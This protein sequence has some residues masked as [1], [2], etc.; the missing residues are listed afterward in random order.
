[1]NVHVMYTAKAQFLYEHAVAIFS[2]TVTHAHTDWPVSGWLYSRQSISASWACTFRI[3]SMLLRSWILEKTYTLFWGGC[4]SPFTR[5]QKLT[6]SHYQAVPR[7]KLSEES[8]CL[9]WS[10]RVL[11]Q[12]PVAISRRQMFAVWTDTDRP[13]ARP[14]FCRLSFPWFICVHICHTFCIH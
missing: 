6:F 5:F 12:H 3:S 11:P 14:A 4:S 9:N 13:D 10:L 7:I 1:M 2:S 8:T